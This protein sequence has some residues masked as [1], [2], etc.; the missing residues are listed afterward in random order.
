MS[1]RHEPRIIGIQITRF[2]AAS[3]DHFD[4]RVVVH[5][6]GSSAR[7]VV[8]WI[9]RCDASGGLRCLCQT[10]VIVAWAHHWDAWWWWWC[11]IAEAG[12]GAGEVTATGSCGPG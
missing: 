6:G 7:C 5:N 11:G 12:A 2:G 8:E 10:L 4:A 1:H 3:V 9:T